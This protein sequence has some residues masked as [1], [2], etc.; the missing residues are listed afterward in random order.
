MA[1]QLTTMDNVKVI[2]CQLL[3]MMNLKKIFVIRVKSTW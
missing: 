3:L 1:A 2:L